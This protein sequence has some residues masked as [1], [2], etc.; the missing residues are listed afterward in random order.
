MESK[1]SLTNKQIQRLIEI[2]ER[3]AGVQSSHELK[4]S[5]HNIAELS[6]GTERWELEIDELVSKARRSRVL[7]LRP[8][9]IE[10][11]TPPD[12]DLRYGNISQ[13]ELEQR[14]RDSPFHKLRRGDK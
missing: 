8:I 10:A 11:Q 12:L 3:L 14:L 13:E 5:C 4:S 2:E 7:R 9:P 1:D 6:E